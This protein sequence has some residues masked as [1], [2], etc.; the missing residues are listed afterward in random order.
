MGNHSG[1]PETLKT[2]GKGWSTFREYVK[3]IVWAVVIALMIR[4]FVV[5]PFKI[6]SGSMED[7]LLIGDHLLANK[8]I[9]GIR[10]P[11]TGTRLLEFRQPRRG[12]V[13]IFKYPED[14]SKDFIKRLIGVPGDVIQ[15]RNKQVFVNGVL[16]HNPQE[17]HKDPQVLPADQGPRDNFGPVT[18]PADSY[19]MMGD[20]RDL[21][22]DSRYWGFVKKS[23]ILG[24]AILIYW[25]WDGNSW[26]V[27]WGRIGKMIN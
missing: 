6:P 12:D 22:Y 11:F 27:R 24:E 5:E 4:T 19:F 21:S 20:N 17:V 10:V 3:S 23:D 18:V 8:F 9:Y 26:R 16:Y 25:S 15:I 1:R 7:T 14:R 13:I 2:E